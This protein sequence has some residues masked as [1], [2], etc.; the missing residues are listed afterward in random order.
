[1]QDINKADN[2]L[3]SLPSELDA[4]SQSFV[5]ALRQLFSVSS[6]AASEHKWDFEAPEWK[7]ALKPDDVRPATNNIFGN[8]ELDLLKNQDL[9]SSQG[10]DFSEWVHL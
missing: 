1:M 2:A 6:Q 8:Q 7:K 3:R 9:S 10:L 4:L 5:I